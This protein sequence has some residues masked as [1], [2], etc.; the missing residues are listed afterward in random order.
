MPHATQSARSAERPDTDVVILGSGLA[1]TAL[2]AVLARGGAS[3]LLIDADSHPR[4]AIGESTSP[5]TSMLMRLVGER[6]DVPEFKDLTTFDSVQRSVAT[7][8]GIKKNFGFLY[9]REGERQRLEECHQSL[10]PRTGH[11][12]NHYFRQDIDAWML[13]VAVKYGARIR[14]RTTIVDIDFDAQGGTLTD[15]RGTT[16]RTRYVVD[17]SGIESPLASKLGLR[18]E[19]P[20]MR[21]HARSLCTHMMNVTAYD[22]LLPRTAHGHPTKWSQGTLHH[23]FEG[24]W[25][26]VIPFNNHPRTTNPLVSVGLNLDPRVH[27][28]VG[29][30][31][32]EEFRSFISRFPDIRAQFTDAVAIRPW[33]RTDRQQYSA[34]KTVGARWCLASHAAGFV[35]PLFSRALSDSFEIVNALAWRLLAALEEDDFSVERFAYVEQLQLGLLRNNDDLAADAYTSFADFRLWDSWLRVHSLGRLL[36]TFEIGRAYERVRRSRQV[37]D[38]ARLEGL[39]P[40]GGIPDHPPVRELLAHVSEQMRSVQEGRRSGD[41]AADN[42][43]TALGKADFAPPGFGLTDASNRWFDAGP[44]KTADTRRW[45]RNSAPPEIGRLVAEGLSLLS[46]KHL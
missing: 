31:P 36:A 1:G 33:V 5:Y 6:Y 22:D 41:I 43:L 32:E 21:H 27:P 3:V 46:N 38:L 2:A 29:G 30:T 23:L 28:D 19:A 16:Y 8:S 12:E 9:H 40:D 4:F 42:I 15:E 37:A 14:Q 44:R 13:N 26:W 39:A 18:D 11:F 25:I 35:D 34:S 17:T 20:V 7:T 24:G 10:I 45:A